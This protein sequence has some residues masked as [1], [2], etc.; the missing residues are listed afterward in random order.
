MS[1]CAHIQTH[2]LD[3]QHGHAYSRV[4]HTGT[5]MHTTHT[6]NT[7]SAIDVI[8]ESAARC[9]LRSAM[10]TA[11]ASRACAAD[12]AAAAAAA[13]AAEADAVRAAGTGGQAWGSPPELHLGARS[14]PGAHKANAPG[15]GSAALA[16]G[17]G[18]AEGI[19]S[20]QAYG[21]GGTQAGPLGKVMGGAAEAVR[22]AGG[23][24]GSASSSSSD[25]GGGGSGTAGVG[26]R[27]APRTDWQTWVARH[28]WRG[29]TE[30][31][32][33]QLLE[34]FG[35]TPNNP[36]PGSDGVYKCICVCA[37]VCMCVARMCV[38]VCASV[39]VC[40]SVC[41]CVC[42]CVYVCKCVCVCVCACVYVCMSARARHGRGSVHG[43]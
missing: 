12:A 40:A 7:F 16:G 2:V 28:G 25:N 8:D 18:G 9:L 39:Y 33:Q 32:R 37:Y 5:H 21:Q 19:S 10:E 6:P 14:G 36:A 17:V 11:E 35:A 38:C 26:S 3:P 13:A 23:G 42:K 30:Y 34:W 1:A 31:E 29:Q 27:G 15:P 4:P 24:G 41:M 43:M 22:A 20:G